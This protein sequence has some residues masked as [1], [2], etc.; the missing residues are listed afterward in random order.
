MIV[1]IC[2]PFRGKNDKEI[3]LNIAKAT[4]YAQGVWRRG[5]TPIVPHY[6]SFITGRKLLDEVVFPSLL[7]VLDRCDAICI[8]GNKITKGMRREIMFAS[9]K[10][11]PMMALKRRW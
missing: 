11:L 2:A 4:E 10:R 9:Q 7:N 1:Y 5:H 6:Q 3:D 8:C